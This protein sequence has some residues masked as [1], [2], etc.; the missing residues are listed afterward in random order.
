M[1]EGPT[2]SEKN[3]SRKLRATYCS[4]LFEHETPKEVTVRNVPL[5][6]IRLVL[7][8]ITVSFVVIYQ[9]WYTRGY[10]EFA[11]VETSLTTK[12]KGFSV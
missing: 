6:Y 11:E 5:G 12:I 4:F 1:Q 3:Y 10:Q 7:H 2:I 8:T 9:L